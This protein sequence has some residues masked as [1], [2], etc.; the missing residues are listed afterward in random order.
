MSE[1]RS[2]YDN[3][4]NIP[5]VRCYRCRELCETA[6]ELLGDTTPDAVTDYLCM[7]CEDEEAHEPDDDDEDW[8]RDCHMDANGYCGKAGSEDCD[9]CPMWDMQ[10]TIRKGRKGGSPYGVRG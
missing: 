10:E 6:W 8:L 2:K 4:H 9:E 5:F 7:A 1:P 3:E